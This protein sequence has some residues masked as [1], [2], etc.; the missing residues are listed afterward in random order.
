M[1]HNVIAKR[2]ALSGFFL[3]RSIIQT[4]GHDGDWSRLDCVGTMWV[5]GGWIVYNIHCRQRLNIQPL[6]T[7]TAHYYN[8]P[9]LFSSRKSN[10]FVNLIF[11]FDFVCIE[12]CDLCN[13]GVLALC[14]IKDLLSACDDESVLATMSNKANT[15]NMNTNTVC[16]V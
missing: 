15:A 5:G 4:V 2:S 12:L 3:K 13:K 8:M 14:G 7:I 11:C 16:C 9:I 6:P 10:N 1:I